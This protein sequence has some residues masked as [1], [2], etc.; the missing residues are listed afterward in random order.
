M[1]LDIFDQNWTFCTKNE[2][3]DQIYVSKYRLENSK[4][5]K[6]KPRSDIIYWKVHETLSSYVKKFCEINI[7]I[8]GK[9]SKIL[10]NRRIH[11]KPDRNQSKLTVWS[12]WKNSDIQQQWVFC[13]S[14]CRVLLGFLLM[15]AGT[16]SKAAV[17]SSQGWEI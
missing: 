11:S 8:F 1:Y 2:D 7:R 9:I 5:G 10:V 6:V 13:K 14:H 17:T 15:C 12:G 16:P 3:F 4:S